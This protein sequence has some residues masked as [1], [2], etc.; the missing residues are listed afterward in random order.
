M[1]E[2]YLYVSPSVGEYLTRA[3]SKIRSSTIIF[4]KPIS[5]RAPEIYSVLSRG[6]LFSLL[7]EKT[8]LRIQIK[9]KLTFTKPTIFSKRE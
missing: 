9:F 8:S 5:L 3:I 1:D 6:T 2:A 7:S 4:L